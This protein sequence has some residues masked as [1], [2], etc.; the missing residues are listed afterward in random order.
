MYM[1]F[2]V[3]DIRANE[4]MSPPNP[5]ARFGINLFWSRNCNIQSIQLSEMGLAY[6]DSNTCD[7]GE[8]LSGSYPLLNKNNIIW[9]NF[10]ISADVSR[11]QVNLRPT[12]QLSF[13]S[14][15]YLMLHMYADLIYLKL[16]GNRTFLSCMTR[17]VLLFKRILF[18]AFILSFSDR[19]NTT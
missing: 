5:S 11:F 16:L 3:H 7:A 14:N 17:Q 19:S 6:L 10:V 9:S 4:T 13:F 1:C 18:Q 15:C 2:S 12:L 8:I